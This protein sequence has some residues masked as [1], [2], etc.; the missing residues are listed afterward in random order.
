MWSNRSFRHSLRSKPIDDTPYSSVA[1]PIQQQHYHLQY[2]IS[3]IL[4]P[5]ASKYENNTST[6]ATFHYSVD[7][8]TTMALHAQA[9]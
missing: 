3:L 7:Y 6:S 2:L 9:V 8:C 5:I 1:P 4:S